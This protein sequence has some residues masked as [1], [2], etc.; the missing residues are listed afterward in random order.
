MS[1]FGQ[2][3]IVA[4]VSILSAGCRGECSGGTAVLVVN[5]TRTELTVEFTSQL[6]VDAGMAVHTV[7]PEGYLYLL[8]AVDIG[9]RARPVDEWITYVRI[10]AGDTEFYAGPIV[11][12]AF[13]LEESDGGYCTYLGYTFT[14][15]P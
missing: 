6:G 1:S 4:L 14:A 13:L 9:T 15:T 11:E 5:Q 10:Y 12:P 3:C 8:D 7:E 2:L